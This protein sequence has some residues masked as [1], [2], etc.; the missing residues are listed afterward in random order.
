MTATIELTGEGVRADDSGDEA[1][2]IGWNRLYSRYSEAI[3]FCADAQDVVNAVE[4]TREGHSPACPQ[5]GPAY[6]NVPNAAA[7]D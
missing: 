4:W 3:V 6:V 1:A 7:L 5:R 2:R